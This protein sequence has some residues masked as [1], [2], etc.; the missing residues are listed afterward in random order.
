MKRIGRRKL[1]FGA[2]WGRWWKAALNWPPLCFRKAVDLKLYLLLLWLYI[3]Y[4]SLSLKMN[5]LKSWFG[6]F[7]LVRA[8]VV[9]KGVG[10]LISGIAD[11]WNRTFEIEVGVCF[12]GSEM[13]R[14][15]TTRLGG[16]GGEVGRVRLGQWS[17]DRAPVIWEH[18]VMGQWT[19]DWASRSW[20]DVLLGQVKC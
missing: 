6:Y 1:V 17:T 8:A 18:V 3:W 13:Q 2:G 7:L 4:C 12:I 11:L 10:G 15:G 19:R 14:L 20:Q 5:F 9:W 16:G